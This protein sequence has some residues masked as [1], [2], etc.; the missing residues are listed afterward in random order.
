MTP[1][2]TPDD[3]WTHLLRSAI[4]VAV[5]WAISGFAL[6]A[7]L[8]PGIDPQCSSDSGT[9]VCPLDPDRAITHLFDAAWPQIPE[10]WGIAVVVV[11]VSMLLGIA[12][13]LVIDTSAPWSKTCGT[14]T[15]PIAGFLAGLLGCGL[16]LLVAGPGFTRPLVA[17]SI[18]GAGVL[19]IA[20]GL[21]GVR[22]FR[23]ALQRRH[24]LH[25]RRGALTQHGTC[26]V[27][28]ITELVWEQR[29]LDE[30]PVFT[31]TATLGTAP[32]ARMITDELCVPREQAPIVGGTVIVIH[33]DQTGHHTGIDVLIE[34][35]PGGLRDPDALEKYPK[36]PEQSPS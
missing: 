33:D 18:T 11:V 4:T 23:N 32:D 27:A 17:L 6:T 16:G 36:A 20:L 31:V 9:G 7:L 21:L 15:P 28:T 10:L 29:Y 25:Q 34:P 24:A 8:L 30:D 1:L 5:L 12:I 14:R 35:D 2:P 22:G 3:G 26:T 13:A 19:L